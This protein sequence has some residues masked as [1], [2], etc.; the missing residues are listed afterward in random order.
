VAVIDN[1]G[2]EIERYKSNVVLYVPTNEKGTDYD[3]EEMLYLWVHEVGHAL[4]LVD[5]VRNFPKVNE[6]DTRYEL[7]SDEKLDYIKTERNA[8]AIGLRILRGIRKRYGINPHISEERYVNNV[9]EPALHS[10]RLVS[11]DFR[12][13]YSNKDRAIFRDEEIEM[14]KR[15]I[16]E[17][18]ERELFQLDFRR[19]RNISLLSKRLGDRATEI[20]D[21]LV[22]AWV[23]ENLE[24]TDRLNQ[25]FARDR[26]E[27]SKTREE[28]RRELM[29][30]Y[31]SAIL[32]RK[33]GIPWD[34]FSSVS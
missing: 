26:L 18:A 16:T 22:Q 5:D 23:D 34:Q 4:D 27:K 21:S 9:V 11:M 10:R 31:H 3:G 19:G 1:E 33:H 7:V 6:A 28:L 32:S 25:V 15:G 2:R 8:H 12:T 29:L 30:G 13:A 17:E 14:K 20:Y 24:K